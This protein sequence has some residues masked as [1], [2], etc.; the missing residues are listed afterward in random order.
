MIISSP[1]LDEIKAQILEE[2]PSY[3]IINKSDSKLMKIISVL[4][5]IV[6][7]GQMKT[8]MTS[9][10][11]T[12]GTTVYVP[13]SWSLIDTAGKCAILRHER[14]HMRQ[15]KRM[16]RFLFSLCY[17]LLPLPLFL[18]WGRA[19]LEMEAYA[20]TLAAW[21][22]YGGNITD[23]AFRADIIGNFTS[24]SYGWMYPFPKKMAA[25][26]DATVKSVRTPL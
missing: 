19:S 7:F 23:D 12:M 18:A 5:M 3:V 2:F 9:F 1:N 14:V 26:Y 15:A 17:V 11:T 16:G 8:Y 22:E 4:L 21:N 20:E 25:W 6:T 13:S 10:I 24:S